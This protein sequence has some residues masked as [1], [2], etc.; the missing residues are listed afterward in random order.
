MLV[1]GRL[2]APAHM[3]DCETPETPGRAAA[4]ILLGIVDT[5]DC[6]LPVLLYRPHDP[7][8]LLLHLKH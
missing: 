2:H 1:R 5:I 6:R 8:S 3:G 7:P 4:T